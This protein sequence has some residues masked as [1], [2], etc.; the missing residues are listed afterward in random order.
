MM[1]DEPN[2]GDADWT[3]GHTF[4]E[5]Q[6]LSIRSRYGRYGLA[7]ESLSAQ[8]HNYGRMWKL[9]DVGS[10]ILILLASS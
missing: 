9:E 10:K 8:V 6:E 5:V 3:R 7:A 2:P 1:P 4:E